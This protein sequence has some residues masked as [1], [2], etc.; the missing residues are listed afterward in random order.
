M[1]ATARRYSL[2]ADDANDAWHRSVEI[3]LRRAASLDPATAHSWLRTVVKHEALAVRAERT[4]FLGHDE[5][6]P[7]A[8]AGGE[9]P[10]EGTERLER[11][12]A[13]A[14]AMQRL[15]PNETEALLLLASGMSYR[16]IGEA[17]GWTYTKVNRLLTE[18]RQAFRLRIEGIESGAEC[19]RWRATLTRIADHEASPD[20]ITAVEPHLSRCGG[21]RSLLRS[22][23]EATHAMALVLPGLATA[24]DLP[25]D[26]PHRLWGTVGRALSDFMVAVG[27]RVQG[28]AEAAAS[29]KVVAVA[30]S[31][32]AIAGGGVVI[33]QATHRAHHGARPAFAA[34]AEPSS[35]NDSEGS[36]VAVVSDASGSSGSASEQRAAS[37]ERAS[38]RKTPP[39]PVTPRAAREFDPLEASVPHSIGSE[40]SAA[41]QPPAQTAAPVGMQPKPLRKTQAAPSQIAPKPAATVSK[42]QPTPEF[43]P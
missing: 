25:D 24:T 7:D 21:C 32:A 26:V 3:L 9:D 11:L 2:C 5:Y 42:P 28:V 34:K 8:F 20:E 35:V 4:K 40:Q 31:T 23:R 1:L 43:G 15:K 22:D 30:A 10:A 13:A 36:Q 17:K 6:D 29:T 16:E 12:A 14:E 18:G 33:E 19:K 38:T 37:Q 41:V 27:L 39:R